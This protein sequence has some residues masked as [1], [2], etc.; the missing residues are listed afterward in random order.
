M[1][2]EISIS[3]EG[4]AD[5]QYSLENRVSKEFLAQALADYNYEMFHGPNGGK[6]NARHK[7]FW[8]WKKLMVE[9]RS[10]LERDCY[11]C[12]K[13]V[14]TCDNGGWAYWIDPEGYNRLEAY[15]YVDCCY[16]GKRVDKVDAHE[17]GTFRYWC[18]KCNKTE[19]GN[20]NGN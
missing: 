15:E 4:W 7:G 17:V 1:A 10:T 20:E 5:I 19:K 16:C 6:G 11:K 14:N 9:T 12:I 8:N 2:W 3:Q 13:E 18:E